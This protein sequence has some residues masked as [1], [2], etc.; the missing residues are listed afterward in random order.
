MAA[1][2]E[3][4]P[5][6]EIGESQERNPVSATKL[7]V[8]DE[9]TG[10]IILPEL[11]ENLVGEARLLFEPQYRSALITQKVAITIEDTGGLKTDPESYLAQGPSG[12]SPSQLLLN[13]QFFTPNP[14]LRGFGPVG[15]SIDLPRMTRQWITGFTGLDE[16]SYV[17]SNLIVWS[18]AGVM[19]PFC[20]PRQLVFPTNQFYFCSLTIHDISKLREDHQ[21]ALKL[22]PVEAADR[23]AIYVHIAMEDVYRYHLDRAH[24]LKRESD[25]LERQIEY[26]E[27]RHNIS[28][29]PVKQPEP[30]VD[31][32]TPP[33]H[34]ATAMMY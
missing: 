6:T 1:I 32:N 10:N 21:S 4:R 29:Q 14:A 7:W 18:K 8:R 19:S 30:S 22:N 26:F 5:G 28:P 27:N 31:Q 23:K 2:A 15:Q 9:R 20:S 24:S 17:K 25:T 33:D 12:N 11:L 16:P 3:A 13:I 34:L